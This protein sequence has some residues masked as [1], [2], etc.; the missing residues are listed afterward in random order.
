M[1][2][3]GTLSP[4]RVVAGDIG[5]DCVVCGTEVGGIEAN[6]AGV[7]SDATRDSESTSIDGMDGIDV[8]DVGVG[9]IDGVGIVVGGIDVDSEVGGI[10]DSGAGKGD[11]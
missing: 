11:G 1:A 3:T 7:E 10:S 2:V 8:S 6:G 4:G 5:V 9:A